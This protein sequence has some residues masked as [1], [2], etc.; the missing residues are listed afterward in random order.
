MKA[1]WVTD[2]SAAGDARFEDLLARLAGAPGLSVQLRERGTPDRD[3]LRWARH[4]R[5]ALGQTTPL[6]VNRR[7]DI[8]LAA[9]ADG[10]HLPASGLPLARVRAAAPRGFHVG[11]STHSAAGASRAIEEGAD[12]VVVGPIFET[13]SKRAYGPPLGPEALGD[14]PPRSDHNCAVYAIG[15]IN[16]GN[17]GR[18]NPYRDRIDGVAAIRYFQEAADPRAAA[19]ELASR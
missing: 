12:V 5:R 3:C 9:S 2:R 17:L 16:E 10:V 15:G 8:A 4:A 1:L 19:E 14:L 7:L 13:P 11:V 6:Y 18:L